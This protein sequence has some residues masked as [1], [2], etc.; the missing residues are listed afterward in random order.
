MKTIPVIIDTDIGSD[1]D[2]T[3]A[4][5]MAFGC[6][7]LDI[8]LITTCTGD[9][10]YRAK[11]V[12]K[13]LEHV[14]HTE[15]PVGLGL[16]FDSLSENQRAYIDGYQ[17]RDYPGEIIDDGV[18]A[19]ADI[20][21]QSEETVTLICLGPLQNIQKLLQI[22]PRITKKARFVGMH[23]AIFRGYKGTNDVQAEY[24]IVQHVDSAKTVFSSDLDMII[25][26]LDT[27]GMISLEGDNYQAVA[28]ATNK[29]MIEV[30]TNYEIWLRALG[31]KDVESINRSSTLFDTVAIYLALDN[32]L[33][34]MKKLC[35][36]ITDE[37]KTVVDET[38]KE[39][40]V[41][42]EWRDQRTF[43]DFLINRLL[44]AP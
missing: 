44:K 26:P 43:Y 29:T 13:F 38:G 25:T 11:I 30:I 41:A 16:T 23:G 24:N 1:I 7:E 32:A 36:K 6:P 2:D 27:C 14:G 33:L 9:T 21:M 39:M 3:W 28:K 5:A 19:M 40:S 35:I 17:L 4:L 8:K 10:T 42:I 15:I 12:C 37:G 18:R 22:E 31:A 34:E 20:I